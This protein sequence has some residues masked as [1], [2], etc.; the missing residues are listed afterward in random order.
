MSDNDNENPQDNHPDP[1]PGDDLSAFEAEFQ[2]S[3][4]PTNPLESHPLLGP[5]FK[6]ISS[7][8]NSSW[9]I[10][11]EVARVT[12]TGGNNEPNIDPTLRIRVEELHLLVTR[13]IEATHG[14]QTT[15][16][17]IL[18]TRGTYAYR[19]LSTYRP[20]L[21]TLTATL[22]KPPA[23]DPTE[24]VAEADSLMRG[25]TQF[26]AP[27][28]AGV[29]AGSLVGHLA[30]VNLSAY[31][32]PLPW[33]T[34]DCTIVIPNIIEAANT[35]SITQD[36][37]IL[38]ALVTELVSSWAYTRPNVV[39]RLRSLLIDHAKGFDVDPDALAEML[40]SIDPAN[41]ENM[42]SAM[43]DPMTLLG[44]T[45]T[46]GQ[47]ETAAHIRAITASITAWVEHRVEEVATRLLGNTGRFE[48]MQKRR[49]IEPGEA[50]QFLDDLLGL[51][52]SDASHRVGK[53]FIT[54]VLERH[55]GGIDKLFNSQE[56][57][58][59]PADIEAPGLWL[60]RQGLID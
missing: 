47:I 19:A 20:I 6:A 23:V 38:H 50:D 49:R 44:A 18:D 15:G 57:L 21:E 4:P 31:S 10:A 52:R 28:L 24:Y 45:R 22:S 58:P 27:S 35:W 55:S 11:T 2:G 30:N 42:R 13:H 12:A 41:P 36:D 32:T 46:P 9:E 5:M 3:E 16:N 26:I 29:Q 56:S 25:L 33:G 60:A 37:M 1:D 40:G 59:T 14:F 51:D 17:L 54:G 34:Q 7:R 48:E 53:E 8:P 43:G 39:D